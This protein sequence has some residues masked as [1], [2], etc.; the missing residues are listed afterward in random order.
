MK[1]PSGD[2]ITDMLRLPEGYR[3]ERLKRSE[4][5]LLI[6]NLAAWHPDISV[7]TASC[8]LRNDLPRR[9]VS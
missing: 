9:D 2:A 8:Y 5:L 6:A 4:I 1:W 3:G 7:G